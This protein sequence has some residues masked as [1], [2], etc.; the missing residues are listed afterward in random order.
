MSSSDIR[1]AVR[2]PGPRQTPASWPGVSETIWCREPH[3]QIT[4]NED[5]YNEDMQKMV[6]EYEWG[7]KILTHDRTNNEEINLLG[8]VFRLP[9]EI[10]NV[11]INLCPANLHKFCIFTKTKFY[12]SLFL[13][14][15]HAEGCP[16]SAGS[17]K[18][19]QYE[20]FWR[21]L[22]PGPRQRLWVSWLKGLGM[23]TG[24]RVG[25]TPHHLYLTRN[26]GG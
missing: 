13:L 24:C 3:F 10:I 20:S 12:N 14:S 15:A 6:P 26:K 7:P 4:A 16:Y 11:H 8:W 21:N 25:N 1:S 22:P 9:I 18:V 23:M 5:V 19:W 2:W 17:Q